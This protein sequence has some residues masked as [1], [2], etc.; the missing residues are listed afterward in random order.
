LCVIGQLYLFL[1]GLWW[2]LAAT[3]NSGIWFL[4]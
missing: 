3:S 4:E 2:L 1:G